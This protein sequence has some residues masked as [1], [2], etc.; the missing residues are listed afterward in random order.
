MN[1]KTMISLVEISCLKK[2]LFV[3]L[4]LF[5]SILISQ[6][7]RINEFMA[8]NSATLT[9]EDGEYSDWIEIYNSGSSSID[10]FN[11]SLT[12]KA[13]K[14]S[15]WKFPSVNIQPNG[16]LIIFASGKDRAISGSELHTNFKLGTEGEYLALINQDGNYI[17]SFSPFFSEQYKDISYAYFDGDYLY[18][19]SPTPGEANKLSENQ[20]LP[21]PTFSHSRGFYEAPFNVTI[22]S[23]L[24]SALIYYTTDGSE[25]G[26][27]NGILYSS[28]I[29][30][31][32]TSLLRAV[33]IKP[34]LPSSRI[35]TS[36]YLFLDDV[37][38]QPSNP[39]G[40]PDKWGSYYEF[41]G[42]ATA[43]YEMDPDITQNPLYAPFIKESLLSLPT[44][45]IVTDKNNLFSHDTDPNKGGIYIYTG[46]YNSF[47]NGWERPASVEYFDNEGVNQFQIDCGLRVHGG[48]SRQPEKTPKHS[49][50]LTFRSD[51]GFSKLQFP[52]FGDGESSFN[53]IVLRAGYGNSWL[54]FNRSERLRHQLIRDVWAKDTQ[55]DMGQYGGRGTYVHLYL[56]GMYWGIYNPTERLD[57]DYGESYFGGNKDNYDVIKDNAEVADGNITAWNNLMNLAKQGMDSQDNYMRLQ[58]KNPDGTD[59]P[60]YPA[61]IDIENFI[62]YMI[63]NFYGANWDWDGHNWVAIRNRVQP[64]KGFKFFSWDAEHVLRELN[65]NSISKNNNNRPTG[66][67]RLLLNNNEFKKL[68]ADRVQLHCFN[69]GALTPQA[70]AERWMKRADNLNMAI[71]AESARW[72]DYR[73]DVHQWSNGPYEL[74]TKEHWLDHQAFLIN[75]YFP[76]RTDVFINQL[77]DAKL[78]P[79]ING[80]KFLINDNEVKSNIVNTGDQ[81]SMNNSYGTIYYTIDGTDPVIND[82]VNPTSISYTGPIEISNSIHIKA[83]LFY[84]NEWSALSEMVFMVESDLNDLKVTEIH[85]HPLEEADVDHKLLEFIELKNTGTTSLDLSGVQFVKGIS[86][87]F[88]LNTVLDV[89]SFIVLA[90]SKEHFSNRYGFSPFDQYEG[91]LDNSGE[92]IVLTSVSGDTIISIRYYDKSPWPEEADGDGYSLVTTEINPTGDQND[93]ANWRI[94]SQIHGSPGRDDDASTSVEENDELI[95]VLYN[96]EQNYP[97]PFNPSTSISFAIPNESKVR[98]EIFNILG[99]RVDLLIDSMLPAGI[100]KSV[101][102]ASALSSGVYFYKLSA[103]SV[104]GLE[105]NK[106][107]KMLLMK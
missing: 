75:T 45:S 105:F 13:D 63:L 42:T 11:W 25:P 106:V 95:P 79:T 87:T 60:G 28:P 6:T 51:Y 96:L 38:K 17:S 91:N 103:K 31:S 10:L 33:V 86:Y 83:R 68:F 20:R 59:N 84:R 100:Y 14:P 8:S 30:I 53:S 102:N 64:G 49:L 56:N 46:P 19:E 5:P 80:P 36:T 55:N 77:K 47:G 37:I 50:R 54:H 3:L 16:Y 41:S 85:Y 48:A 99:Q 76:Q 58:G 92:R 65:E 94:S 23:G 26:T 67:F 32:T 90:S 93:P 78:F 34:G 71:I 29:L 72:G 70:T 74:Y 1:V 21:E 24:T 15:M 73:R 18:S 27:N 82:N 7:I 43:D 40:Y 104:D 89:G 22:S 61:Y 69:G 101:W 2:F 4:I 107:K 66:L 57:D 62:D 39:E 98:L 97:N 12:D 81:L 44:M 35:S 52:L 88:P 9:D